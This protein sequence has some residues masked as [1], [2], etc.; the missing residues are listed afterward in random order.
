MFAIHKQKEHLMLQSWFS[1]FRKNII[2]IDQSFVTPYG[3][4]KIVYT[5]WT[6]SGRLYKPI[7]D[8]IQQEIAPFV[9]N[10]HTETTVTGS[11]MTSAYHKSLAHIKKHVGAK[12]QDVIIASNSGMTGVVNKFQRILGLKV[13]EKFRDLLDIPEKERP[14]VIC[15]HMEHH[16]NQ[17]SWLETVADLEV[18]PPTEEGLV[19]LE[20]L[21]RLLGKYSNRTQKIAAI[22]S[23]SNVTGVF[24]PYFEIAE[25]MHRHG[26]LCFVD[27]ACSAPY[28]NID[29]H[30]G[31]EGQHLDAI[32]FSPHKFLGGPGSSGVLV[33]DSKLYNNKVPD[34]P[35][36]GT[37]AWTNPWGGHRYIEE[38]EA[39]EDGGTPGFLQAIKIGLAIKLKEKME[40]DKMLVR[41]EELMAEIWDRLER[42]SNLHIL[43]S[44]Q[45][46]RLGVVSFYI[47]NLH[48]NLAVKILNDRYGIQM[49]GG[50][51]C[52]G[53]YGHYLLHMSEQGSKSVT[54][55]ID[56][57]DLS[58]KPG[59]VRMSIHP[60]MTDA[61]IDYVLTA[62]QELSENFEDWGQ[63]YEYSN[64]TNEYHFTG[65]DEFET[66]KVEEWFGAALV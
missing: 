22:T 56:A 7:E 45:R 64:R 52:A 16:S 65:K 35:G 17:T 5:D 13:H 59:W 34:N 58:Y 28:I 26:G 54:D 41:E 24:T 1:S 37:V 23:C 19:D 48:Y 51:S 18:I 46:E 62:I 3:E 66:H 47:D 33:F 12:E 8:L 6:A 44:G 15:T 32:Y 11:L 43:A 57:G 50:C 9:G 31:K 53:T 2:G 40:V 21:E 42:I 36:G 20:Y 63:A 10:T 39:R 49:R 38:I 27:F 55:L 29:M 60:T 14:V 61:E 30:N 4:K 25:I